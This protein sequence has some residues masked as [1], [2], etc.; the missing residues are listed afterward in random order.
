MFLFLKETFII[1]LLCFN[2][3][4]GKLVQMTSYPFPVFTIMQKH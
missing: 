3:I 4:T 1:Y 2:Q